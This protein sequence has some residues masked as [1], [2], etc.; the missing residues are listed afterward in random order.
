MPRRFR[1]PVLAAAVVAVLL[2]LVVVPR[3]RS[4][5]LRQPG[6]APLAIP[7]CEAGSAQEEAV[8]A[9][10]NQAVT[11][12]WPAPIHQAWRVHSVCVQGDQAFAFVKSYSPATGAPLPI[13]SEVALALWTGST[14]KVSLPDGTADYN[15]QLSA[16]SESLVPTI[17]RGVLAESQAQLA[18]AVVRPSGY[19]LPYPHGESAHVIWHWYAAL[20]FSIAGQGVYGTVRNAK[21]GTAV[22]VKDSST[23]ECGDPPPDWY[24]WMFANGLVIQS[25]PA[26][27]VWYLHLAANSIPDWIQE[28]VFVPA[29]ADLG[30]EGATGWAVTDHVH[31]MVASSFSCCDG[32]GDQRIPHWPGYGTMRINFD[33]G[34]WETLP[35][36]AYSQNNAAP[37][38]SPT[39]APNTGA[40]T[41]LAP[42]PEAEVPLNAIPPATQAPAQPPPAARCPNPYTVQRG[43]YLIRIAAACAVD[44]SA[45]VAANPGLNPNRI[46]AGQRLSLPAGAASAPATAPPAA[47]LAAPTQLPA[48][49]APVASPAQPVAAP[50]TGL[51]TV[52]PN[53]N[54][55]RIGYDCGFSLAQMAAANGLAHPYVIYPGQVLRFP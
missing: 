5:G 33:E 30:T 29:G 23:R 39:T 4:G 31:F 10:V 13:E 46:F 55:F 21:A 25:G 38:L 16:L 9:V 44:F 35:F 34:T 2:A 32:E 11:T 36:Q 18:P 53:E 15:A 20:D 45:L 7:G 24:C 1:P 40:A 48:V 3:I 37:P 26:E 47:P 8:A 19:N 54:L 27:Y 50:C 52:A 17:A 49:P 14:W 28:G 43:D 51:H 22:F 42:P 12:R 6:A 41:P